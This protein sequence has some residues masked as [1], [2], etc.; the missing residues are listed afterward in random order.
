MK[1]RVEF[2]DSLPVTSFGEVAQDLFALGLKRP[3]STYMILDGGKRGFVQ[4]A[5]VTGG[6]IAEWGNPLKP[7]G[8]SG[9]VARAQ[10]ERDPGAE[11]EQ[12]FRA[13]EGDVLNAAEAVDLLLAFWLGKPRPDELYW[14]ELSIPAKPSA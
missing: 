7:G 1:V 6:Y 12:R 10:K 8:K 5:R 3:D 14:R 2:F 11:L 9:G 4:V 13:H